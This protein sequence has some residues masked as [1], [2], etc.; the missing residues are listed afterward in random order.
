M[1]KPLKNIADIARE[2]FASVATETIAPTP[3]AEGNPDAAYLTALPTAKVSPK[4]TFVG[5]TAD[6]KTALQELAKSYVGP[7][8]T[9][10]YAMTEKEVVDLV[11][12]VATNRRFSLVEK[13][14]SE[15]GEVI[16]D[17]DGQPEMCEIDHFELE[18]KRIFAMRDTKPEK[19]NYNSKESL[20]AQMAKIKASLAKLGL[21][22]PE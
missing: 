10:E 1:P 16:Y 13:V 3:S 5:C 17:D 19:V 6:T 4:Q 15:T 9:K 8:V 21:S 7:G 12:H 18:V 20:L 11:F 22:L 14:D 2:A